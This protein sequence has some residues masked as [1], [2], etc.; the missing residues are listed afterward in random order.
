M[1]T[2]R[3]RKGD[4]GEDA[5][6]KLGEEKEGKKV[7]MELGSAGMKKNFH[8]P[9]TPYGIQEEFMETVYRVLEGGGGRVGILE[10][11]TGTVCFFI[12]FWFSA[13]LL[14]IFCVLV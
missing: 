5:G 9:F 12:L 8:H 13:C 3:V 1:V 14:F 4:G 2:E 11:P 7:V 10:S 6:G